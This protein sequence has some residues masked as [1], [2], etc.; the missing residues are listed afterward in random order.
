M[1]N[2]VYIFCISFDDNSC[3]RHKTLLR[4]L[5]MANNLLPN[6]HPLELNMAN[7]L[8]ST[9]KAMFVCLYVEKTN[10]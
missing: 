2:Y 3:M 4:E 1:V 5:T 7:N 6:T 9:F 10:K 8:L